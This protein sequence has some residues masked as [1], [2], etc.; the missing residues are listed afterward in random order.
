MR[1]RTAVYGIFIALA[2]TS[3][4]GGHSKVRPVVDALNSPEFRARE[5]QTGLFT[6]SEARIEGDTLVFS[7]DC[8]DNVDFGRIPPRG[9]D[10]LEQSATLELSDLCGDEDFRQGIEALRDERMGIRIV[11]RDTKGSEI[12]VALSPAAILGAGQGR[13]AR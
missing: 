13:D 12:A 3:C 5:L 1:I 2:A 9:R 10:F 11:W 7:L 4:G 6:G 8:S